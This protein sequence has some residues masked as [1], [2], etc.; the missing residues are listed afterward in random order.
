[1]QRHHETEPEV[2]VYMNIIVAQLESA[3][4]GFFSGGTEVK[5]LKDPLCPSVEEEKTA[6]SRPRV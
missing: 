3:I 6:T 1:M 2:F 5:L 4:P